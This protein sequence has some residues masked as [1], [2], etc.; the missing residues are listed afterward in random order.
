[1]SIEGLD[2]LSEYPGVQFVF[3]NRK[4]GDVIDWRKGSHE[5][6][7]LVIGGAP[8]HQGLLAARRFVYEQVRITYA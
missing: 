7:F 2:Q 5:Y 8:D 3:L 6:V 4:P 1:V